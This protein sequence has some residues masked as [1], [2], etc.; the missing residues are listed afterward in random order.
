MKTKL[1]F[2]TLLASLFGFSQTISTY[3]NALSANYTVVTSTPAIDQSTA[4][5]GLT[6]NFNTFTS[7]GTSSDVHT[8]P[9]STELVDYPGTTTV[10][11]TTSGSTTTKLFS[12]DIANE[13]SLTGAETTDA[14]FNYNTDNALIGTFPLSYAYNNTDPISGTLT[15][16]GTTVSFTGTINTAVDATGT[17]NM[18]DVGS[19][20]YGANVTRLKI[21]Q[22]ISFTAIIFPGTATQTTY[23]YYDN[24]TG[25]LVFRNT[26][27][28]L[29]VPGAGISEN[30]EVMEVLSNVVLGTSEYSLVKNTL[31]IFPNPVSDIL[32]IKLSNSENIKA[33]TISDLNGRVVYKTNELNSELNVN[34]LSKGMYFV[35][36]ETNK[37]VLTEEFIKK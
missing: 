22:N 28:N 37:G 14:D 15:Y 26:S 2:I 1:L 27:I 32:N 17:L 10:Q 24:S 19:G 33:L 9:T 5:T 23:N 34:S 30:T 6:W 11:T 21:I 7:A 3:N 31:N 16:S 35:S 25:N 36:I 20:A 8:A 4:G 13:I 18:N 29:S 12:K